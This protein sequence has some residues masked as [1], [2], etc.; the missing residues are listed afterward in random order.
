MLRDPE[1]DEFLSVRLERCE[2]TF[3]VN[4]H[5]ATVAGNIGR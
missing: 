1:I 3:L 2:R 4:A 5:E